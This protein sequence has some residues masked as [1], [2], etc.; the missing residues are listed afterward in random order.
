MERF[1]LNLPL[2]ECNFPR[3]E[4]WPA[5]LNLRS[6][7][8]AS[9]PA[10]RDSGWNIFSLLAAFCG[11]FV[12]AMSMETFH[13]HSPRAR[14]VID[15]SISSGRVA[16]GTDDP[17][18]SPVHVVFIDHLWLATKVPSPRQA[19]V[20]VLISPSAVNSKGSGN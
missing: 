7:L 6:C 14:Q 17:G 18:L 3:F 16:P 13:F 1:A 5:S 2:D 20:R 11:F 8:R 4:A 19:C 10:L 12:G 15:Q 9:C